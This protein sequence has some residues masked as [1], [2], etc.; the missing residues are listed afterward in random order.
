[1]QPGI[2]GLMDYTH[3]VATELA[4]DAVVRDRR[5]DYDHAACHHPMSSNARSSVPFLILY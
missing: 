2:L 5:P 1:M 3:A 4:E